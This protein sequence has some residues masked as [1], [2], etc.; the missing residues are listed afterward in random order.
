MLIVKLRMKKKRLLQ[1]DVANV[2]RKEIRNLIIILFVFDLSFL[3][4]EVS[5]IILLS[6]DLLPKNMLKDYGCFDS[7]GQNVMCY[8]YPIAMYNFFA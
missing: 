8:P 5:D 4:R 7:S 1:T 6:L 3:L 2:F